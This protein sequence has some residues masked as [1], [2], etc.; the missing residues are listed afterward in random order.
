[1]FDSFIR[2]ILHPVFWF[3]FQLLLSF[4]LIFFGNPEVLDIFI[5]SVAL[6]IWAFNLDMYYKTKE[7]E[8][9]RTLKRKYCT[10]RFR[11]VL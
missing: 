7:L 11:K 6:S 5:H 3:P 10:R 8:Q 9:K 4:D 1:M 2:K